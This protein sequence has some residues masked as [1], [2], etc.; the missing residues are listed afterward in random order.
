MSKSD[1]Q[2]LVRDNP[3][4]APLR[5]KTIL[6]TRARAQSEDITEQ[7]EAL[8]AAVIHCPT[9]EVVPPSSWAQLDASIG[10]IREYD[11]IV[12]TSANGARF[13]FRRLGEMRSEGVEALAAHVVCAIGPATARAI[14]AAGAV[15]HVTASDSKGEGALTAIIDHVG[16][17]ENVR[18][19]RFLI[20]RARVAREILP[21]GLR[22]LGAHVDAVETYQTV[23]PDVQPERIIR[24]FKENSIDAITFTS[25]STVSNF[26]ELVGLTDLSDLL[27]TTLVACI[28]PVTAETAVS[29]GLRRIIQPEQ[30]N[31]AELVGSIVKSIGQE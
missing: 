1:P 31:A 19:L 29:H 21:A 26:A 2:G 20:P 14:E 22:S 24:L 30:H 10:K 12:F 7:L 28:G 8:G 9:I 11:W 3:E 4:S 13:F 5:G 27:G 16:G 18:G 15:A 23:K 6:V 17:D 25:S